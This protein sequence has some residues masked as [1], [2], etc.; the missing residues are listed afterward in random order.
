MPTDVVQILQRL[1][2]VPSV[3][4]MG[5]DDVATDFESHLTTCL[6]QI[7]GEIG[8]EVTRQGVAP[9]RENVVAQLA[10]DPNRPTVLFEAHQDTVPTDGMTV[11]PFGGELQGGRVY[12]RGACD[13]KGPMAAM[14]AAIARL[15]ELPAEDRPTVIMACTVNEEFG[16]TGAREL[17][18]TWTG[19]EADVQLPRPDM[20]IVAEPTS[21]DVVVSHRGNVRWRC[22][23]R[24]RAAHTSRPHMGKNAIYAMARVVTAI[25]RYAGEVLPT[26]GNDGFCGPPTACVSIIHGGVSVNTVPD[27]CTIEID[28]RIVPGEDPAYARAHL[29]DYLDDHVD[30]AQIEHEPP[31]AT[32]Y[33]LAAGENTEL[34]G[35]L[36][37]VSRKHGGSGQV[38]GVPYGTDAAEI[39]STGIPAVVFGPGHIEQAHTVDE[40]IDVEE[41]KKGSE[42]Y[43]EF[44][45]EL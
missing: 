11:A 1:I 2:A 14:I 22:H 13:V 39:A 40:W 6:Q 5:R 31:Y 18:K 34:A 43:F 32:A 8:L 19:G 29:I 15:A 9:K 24:G 12:G 25:E 45:Q 26:L 35:R 23:T 10:G 20:A 42:I 38:V 36:A 44:L 21:L 41:L 30:D 37:Q 16:F 27:R 28:R 33:G 17:V 4:P 3:N 7:F